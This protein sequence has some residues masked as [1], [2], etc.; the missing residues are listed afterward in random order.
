MED[1]KWLLKKWG[2]LIF[3]LLTAG[4]AGAA[5]WGRLHT[6]EKKVEE[7]VW[8]PPVEI[9]DGE[10]IMEEENDVETSADSAYWF[11]PK[12]SD[13]LISEEEKEQ[14]ESTALSAAEG[15]CGAIRGGR[16]GKRTVSP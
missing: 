10:T 4:I 6:E 9:E 8:E 11:L 12:S 5:C 14:L 1:V 2:F 13:C 15:G 7:E 3:I 16:F